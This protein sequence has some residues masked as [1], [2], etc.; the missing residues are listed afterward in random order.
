MPAVSLEFAVAGFV[1]A[2]IV[3][4]A[5]GIRMAD[6]ADR[7]ADRT[8]LGEAVVGGLLLGMSTSLSGLVTSITAA[9]DGSVSLA[10]SNAVGGIAAQT[11]F[12]VVAD[13]V[14]REINLEHAAADEKHML[15]AA[16]L[17]LMLSLPLV[18]YLAPA[19]AIW[20]IHPVTMIMVGLYAFGANA[21]FRLQRNPMWQP[22]V[23]PYTAKDEPAAEAQKESLQ[24]LSLTF[25]GLAVILA[26]AGFVIDRKSVV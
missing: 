24:A 17:L 1:M 12:L 11:V 23:T 7:L 2:A 15:Q 4:A 10:V 5:A 18:A 3:I 16:V 21:A 13:I 6:I 25:A 20:G 9:V 14:Y 26:L 19:Y 22:S 8:G